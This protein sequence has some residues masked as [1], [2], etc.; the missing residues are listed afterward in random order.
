MKNIKSGE[1]F[2]GKMSEEEKQDRREQA[3]QLFHEFLEVLGYDV[4]NDDNLRQ[5]PKRVVKVMMDEALQGTYIQEPKMTTFDNNGEYDGII[6]EGN[7]TVHSYCAHHILPIIGR[8][9]VAYIANKNTK[10]IGLSKIN[11][12]VKFFSQR[13]Q[14]QEQLTNQIHEYLD[15]LLE[16]NNGIAVMIEATH[17]CVLFRGVSDDSSTTTV[18]LSGSFLDKTDSSKEEFYKMV[19]RLSKKTII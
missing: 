14:Q 2:D 12:V 11:R 10:I 7:C 4:D 16:G 6:F 18:K 5:T 9:H 1:T 15:K 17:L 13:L 8:C 19:D 3:E